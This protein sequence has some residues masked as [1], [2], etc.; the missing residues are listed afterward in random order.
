MSHS[1]A[2][3]LSSKGTGRRGFQGLRSRLSRNFPPN[4]ARLML[5]CCA[6]L[7][8][9]SYLVSKIAMAAITP[10]WLMAMRTGGACLI[11]LL[12]F[13]KSLIPALK[14]SMLVPALIVGATYWGT[15]VLQTKGL[16]T[17]DPGRSAFL[18]ASYCVLTPFAAWF[19]TKNRPHN[20]NIIAG[21]ICL[22]GVGLVALKPGSLTLSLSLGDILT[23]SCAVVFS[24]NLTYLG[25][26]SKKFNALAVTFVQFAVAFVL[27][28]IGALLTEPMPNASWLEPKIVISFLYLFIGATTLAQIMQN[29]GLAHVS[30][31]SASVVMCTESLF[32]EMFSIL[33]WGTTLRFTTLIGFA[34]IFLAVL[35]SIVRRSTIVNLFRRVE[36]WVHDHRKK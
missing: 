18:T 6:A 8:G 30:A 1:F 19:A 24:F 32:S 2:A 28:L 10:Q 14:K 13:H 33:F 23:L 27:F 26:Y 36:D 21:V 25:I 20:I 4:L 12:L 22:I 11:M 17:I 16:L 9:G 31:P 29:I 15:M 7:W 34:L 3:Y 5:L 35:M